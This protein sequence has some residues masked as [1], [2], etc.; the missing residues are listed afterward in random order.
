MVGAGGAPAET[1]DDVVRAMVLGRP[2]EV[3]LDVV[4]G[5]ERRALVIRP[6]ARREA[7]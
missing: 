5:D 4:R 6:R 3:V 7:A 2:P 1:L